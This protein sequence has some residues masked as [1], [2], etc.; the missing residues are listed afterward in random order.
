MARG[1]PFVIFLFL[2]VC[3][4]SAQEHGLGY[5]PEVIRGEVVI[6]LEPIYGGYVDPEYPLDTETA[7][8]RALEEAAL[9]F[10][11]MIYGWSFHYDIGERARQIP[12]SLELTL[13]ANIPA[14]DP[15]L[16][17]TDIETRDMRVRL[18]ADYRLT[19]SQQR[20]LQVWRTGTIRNAQATGYGPLDGV[21]PLQETAEFPD[22]L[23]VK[24]TALEDAARAAIR[25]MLRGGERNRPKEAT[26]FIGLAAFP[27]YFMD[28]GRWAAAARFRVQI[29]DITPF[30]AY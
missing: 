21:V 14:G 27:R 10:S 5:N 16:R 8:R 15:G 23:R 6:E 2:T 3:V 17:A 29:M 26:G 22:W 11:A 25:N 12:E 18:W 24:K 28:S 19:D 1:F 20:R 13:T 9:S 30:A 7:V 4:L